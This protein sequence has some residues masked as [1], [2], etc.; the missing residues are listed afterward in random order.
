[1]FL[2]MADGVDDATWDWHRRR[3]DFSH[4]VE[5]SIKDH[6]LTA[7]LRGLEQSTSS[8]GEAR[9]SVRDAIERRYTLPA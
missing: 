5:T 9:R 8:A 2:E 1:M 6:D 7:E 3:G 4:W